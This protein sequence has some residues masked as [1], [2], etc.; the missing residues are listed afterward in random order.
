MTIKL[1]DLA[2]GDI[3]VRP[4]PF[5]WLAKFALLH[6]G[7]DFETVPLRFTEK[8]NYPDKDHGKLPILVDGETVICDSANIVA[9]AEKNYTGKP[10]VSSKAEGAA[11]DFYSAWLG[12]NLF[13]KLGPMMFVRVWVAADEGDK[14]YF[15][16]TREARFGGKTLEELAATPGLAQ[17]VE[18]A[19]QT[20]AAPLVR[21]RFLGGDEPNLADYIV[22]SPIM[23]QRSL[24][25]EPLYEAPQAVSAW[26]E[27][28]LDLFDGYGRRAKS[29]G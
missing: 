8:D 11:A 1:Y 22:F 10:L 21:Y 24:T 26:Q 9:H 14:D 19:L 17:G 15:R 25:L 18:A 2:L 12:A 20:L 4:S 13:P 7:R 28:M 23:W 6:K 3:E 16:T 5:C 27:R 29:A